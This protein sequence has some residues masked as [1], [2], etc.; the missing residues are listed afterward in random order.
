MQ[1]IFLL[2]IFVSFE[3]SAQN[4][5][6]IDSLNNILKGKKDEQVVVDVYNELA[7]E[8]RNS[9]IHLTDSFAN[10]AISNAEKAKYW[11]GLGN[12]YINKSFV[13]RNAAQYSEALHSCRWALVQFV[14][15][16]YRQGY[17]SAYNNIAGVHYLMSNHAI[18][19]YYYFQSLRISEQ[20]NDY[21]GVARTLNNIGVVYLEQK[22]YDKALI[23]FN[24]CYNILDRLGDENGK[25]DCL[26]NIGTIYQMRDEID[27]AVLNYQK[28]AAINEK[29]GDQ[30]DVSSAMHN[31]GVAYAKTK[32]YKDALTYYHR[33]LLLDEKL[34]DIPSII[35]TYES[36][37]NCYIHLEMFHAALKYAKVSLQM[38]VGFDMKTDVMN[39]YELLYRIE[40]RN[41]N[42]KEAL[43][44][45]EKFKIYSDSIY[46]TETNDRVNDLEEQ[47]L[48]EKI[49]KQ[50]IID[51]KEQEITLIRTQEKE[52]AV[53]QYIFIIGLVLII[54]VSLI[55][56]VFFLLRRTKYS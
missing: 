20:L 51:T 39:A 41:N 28:C 19:Q 26:N 36:I 56:I 33:S 22:Q 14:K 2:L 37:A 55:Y 54:F 16:G 10:L 40:Q 48:K 32:N 46:N 3:L 34:G 7:W 18:A 1:R 35:I 9:N 38:A 45:H 5:L 31:I 25:A 50:K 15:S 6:V 12:G 24:K 49:E 43:A 30:K 13:H 52:H 21:K 27:Q 11:K 47:Y 23:Y 53:T 44:Y 8:Y 29:L 4:K 17:S 42:Y